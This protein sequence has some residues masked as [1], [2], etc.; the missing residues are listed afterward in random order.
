M[1]ETSDFLKDLAGDLLG[2]LDIVTWA[3]KKFGHTLDPWQ[4][5]V[6]TSEHGKILLNIHRQAGK[7]VDI[8][9]PI[10]TPSGWKTMGELQPG[11][12]VYDESGV[13]RVVEWCSPVRERESYRVT[14]SDR[15]EIIADGEHL[16]TTL[17]VKTRMN[18]S[19]AGKGIPD[20]W[21]EYESPAREKGYRKSSNGAETVDTLEM[22]DTIGYGKRGDTN[23]SIPATLPL[24]MPEASL[25]IDPYILGYWLGDGSK[26]CGNITVGDEDQEEVLPLFEAAGYEINAKKYEYKTGVTCMLFGLHTQLRELD[27]L[28]DKHIPV[29]Y[30]RASAEQRLALLQGLMDSDGYV[31]KNRCEFT[32][33]DL[34]LAKGVYELAT[35]LGIIVTWKEGRATLNGVD[36]GP[37]YRL[38]FCPPINPFRLTRKAEAVD[39]NGPRQ[40][41]RRLRYVKSVEPVGLRQVKC[42]AVSGP[43]N[44]FLCGEA[45]I[46]TH[47][48]SMAALLSLYMA[49]V[50]PGSLIILLSPT[51]RQSGELLHTVALI[52]DG[53]GVAQDSATRIEFENSS[54]ILS[55]PGSEKT[56]RG[57]AGV[58]LLIIDEASRVDDELYY[59]VR[60]M[61]AVSGGRLIGMSTPFGKRGWFYDEWAKGVG[62]MREKV[63]AWECPRITKEFLEEERETL[64]P[65]WF[66][67]EYECQFID[68]TSSVFALDAIDLV[69]EEEVE[70]WHL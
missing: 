14:F 43:S 5:N 59:S 29:Q 9:T 20:N 22:R 69:F 46:P 2:Q 56:T 16:W 62:W 23:H 45:M 55:L 6:L 64:G 44:L 54:R 49:E 42:I 1:A 41:V 15:S 68:A 27:V 17:D 8:N 3:E 24:K 12:A 66:A 63:T 25:P 40:Q 51:Q 38:F 37:K 11:D 57:Y 34:G 35:S 52:N 47:N 31:S 4:K 32:N 7:A 13:I 50:E 33:T 21:W 28:N 53:A 65:L 58:D 30:L 61:L 48:S 19:Q 67:Q 39:F 10:P 18:L 26:S 70:R 36:C 60:P